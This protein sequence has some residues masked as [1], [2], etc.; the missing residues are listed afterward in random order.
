MTQRRSDF[1]IE[2]PVR[3]GPGDGGNITVE[4]GSDS[5]LIQGFLSPRRLSAHQIDLLHPWCQV[6]Q[7]NAIKCTLG[8]SSAALGGSELSGESGRQRDL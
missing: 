6:E 5:C 3:R 4:S 1:K 2:E 8:L 7:S